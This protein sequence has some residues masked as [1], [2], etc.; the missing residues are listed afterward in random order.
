M[1]VLIEVMA[2]SWTISTHVILENTK[3]G[4]SEN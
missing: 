4:G 1:N 3:P 2:K